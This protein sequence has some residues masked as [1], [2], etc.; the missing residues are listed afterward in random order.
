MIEQVIGNLIRNATEAMAEARSPVRE[1]LVCTRLQ[2]PG[3]VE[4]SI[5][6]TGPGIDALH[7]PHLFDQFY[8]TKPEGV[9]MGLAISRSIIESHTGSLKVVSG[10]PGGAT[11]R[12]QLKASIEEGV[13]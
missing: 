12:F 2:A 13:A 11:F 8:T 1:V 4:V 9:G 7:L 5:G 3:W 10:N 6:D